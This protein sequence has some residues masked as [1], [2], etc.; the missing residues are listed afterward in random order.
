MKFLKILILGMIFLLAAQA[1]TAGSTQKDPLEAAL[2]VSGANFELVDMVDW[3][4]IN[5]DFLSF[6]QMERIKDRIIAVFDGNGQNFIST[7]ESDEMYRI[8][9]TKGKL[10]SGVYLQIILQTVKLPEEYEKEPQT[11]L[12]VTATGKD[13]DAF[14]SL[15]SKIKEAVVLSGGMSR[16]TTCITASF[17][18]KL[19]KVEQDR[20]I[21][22]ITSSLKATNLQK[23]EDNAT[24]SLVGYSPL[25]SEGVEILGENYN[26]NIAVRYNSEDDKTYLWM[27]TPVISVE[28]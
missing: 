27:G 5:R 28:Y 6:E 13:F 12:V 17:N 21:E 1:V 23:M 22:K 4:I 8:L 24:T 10:K 18:G 7:K 3:S 15:K 9:N 25:L 20:I 14:K 26:I 2:S 16:I 19:D 11:Y